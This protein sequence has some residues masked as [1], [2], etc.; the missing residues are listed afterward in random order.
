MKI[1]CA[2]L[3]LGIIM[4]LNFTLTLKA[5]IKLFLLKGYFVLSVFGIKAV[6]AFVFFSKRC[7]TFRI[8]IRIFGFTVFFNLNTDRDDVDSVAAVKNKYVPTV[9]VISVKVK[10]RV[11]RDNNAMIAAMMGV[12]VSS[13]IR[14]VLGYLSTKQDL[15]FSVEN[16]MSGND[17]VDV[18][19]EIKIAMSLLFAS[20]ETV[21]FFVGKIKAQL[22]NYK[23]NVNDYRTEKQTFGK[24]DGKF[25]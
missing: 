24:V 7:R 16:I 1:Y 3:I 18:F 23:E 8:F 20:V 10:T 17:R 12:F 15:L 4:Y 25:V 13:M 21:R 2:F 5:R 22:K 11:G 14:T 9:D 19:L 6:K